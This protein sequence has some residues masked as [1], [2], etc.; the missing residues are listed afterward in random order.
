MHDWPDLVG[1]LASFLLILTFFM[2]NMVQLR[3]IAI[4]SSVAWLVYGFA[5]ML[6]PVIVLH[7]LFP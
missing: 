7:L 1:Y 3:M 6:Y 5:S 2:R 4:G